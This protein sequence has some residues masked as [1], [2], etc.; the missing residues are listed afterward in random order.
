M[1]VTLVVLLDMRVKVSQEVEEVS[2]HLVQEDGGPLLA[3]NTS[4]FS[5]QSLALVYPQQS[6]YTN[7]QTY[8]SSACTTIIGHTHSLC[9]AGHQ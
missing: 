7:T 1:K 2:L 3:I 4:L 5:A 6:N 8:I 9:S